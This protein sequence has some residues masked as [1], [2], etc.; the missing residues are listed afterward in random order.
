[1]GLF[2]S[3]KAMFSGASTPPEPARY[4]EQYEDYEIIAEPAAEGGQY[5]INGLI[6]FQEKEHT[7]IRADLLPSE[8]LCAQETFRK[9]KLMIDQQGER[10]FQE[11]G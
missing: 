5:R 7:F 6:R 1:M 10:L 4:T 9:A 2:D 8:E 3:L 11:R